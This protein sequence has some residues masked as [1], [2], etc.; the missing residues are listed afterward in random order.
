MGIKAGQSNLSNPKGQPCQDVC[1]KKDCGPADPLCNSAKMQCKCG[2]T[3]PADPRNVVGEIAKN[4]P[5]EWCHQIPPG[6]DYWCDPKR[7]LF[8]AA[9]VGL[10]VLFFL[11]K[12]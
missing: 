11:V 4:N 3:H 12:K 8:G 2:G 10:I 5:F 9:T 1:K 6:G 7:Q